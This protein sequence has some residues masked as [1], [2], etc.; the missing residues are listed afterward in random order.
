MRAVLVALLWMARASGL[1]SGPPI[2]WSIAGSDSGGG[3]GVEADLRTF[4]ALGVHGCAVVTSLTAQNSLGV[5]AALETPPSHVAATIAAL[6][7]DLAPACVKVGMLSGAGAAAREVAAFL[8]RNAACRLVLDPVLASS[9]GRP[10]LDAAGVAVLVGELLPRCAV[11]TPNARE[12]EALLGLEPGSVRTA[13]DV[14]AAAAAFLGR[15]GCGSVLLGGHADLGDAADFWTDGNRTAWLAG[16]RVAGLGA[17][18]A[19]GTGCVLVGARGAASA[20]N[21]L[22]AAVAAKAFCGAAIAL[23]RSGAGRRRRTRRRRGL[24]RAPRRTACRAGLGRRSRR[25]VPPV[26]ACGSGAALSAALR[27]AVG[28]GRRGS[29]AAGAPAA[30]WVN[31]DWRLAARFGAFGAHL[32][33]EDLAAL[34]DG[35]LA[36]LRDSGLRLGVSTHCLSE[37]AVAAA[38]AP[39]YV[40]LGPVFAT[41]SKHVPFSPRGLDLVSDWRALVPGDVPLVAI[42]GV[43]LD[44]AGGLGHGRGPRRVAV[45]GVRVVEAALGPEELVVPREA[46]DAA[47]GRRR[48]ALQVAEAVVGP[49]PVRAVADD[50]ARLH[51][52]GAAAAPLVAASLADE[53]RRAGASRSARPRRAD[54]ADDDDARALVG[55]D[56]RAGQVRPRAPSCG[57]CVRLGLACIDAPPSRRGRAV[58]LG[59]KTLALR[60]QPAGASIPSLGGAVD[61][62]KLIQEVATRGGAPALE[63]ARGSTTLFARA[64]LMAA[65]ARAPLAEVF[66]VEPTYAGEFAD[67]LPP[68]NLRRARRCPAAPL[69]AT[70]DGGRAALRCEGGAEIACDS[71]WAMSCYHGGRVTVIATLFREL[72]DG[73]PALAP[74]LGD[75]DVERELAA[76]LVDFI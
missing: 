41:T 69:H 52:H 11:A 12:A 73:A 66:A 47:A 60:Q 2:A 68:G 61:A 65:Q 14:E 63:H 49:R 44:A 31:D 75:A 8:E 50:V 53:P 58:T 64:A 23:R 34:G 70:A 27:G 54:V 43:T 57:R 19:H 33:Q 24:G 48:E 42:G 25:A 3:A 30:L 35:D 1:R 32:G 37:L 39:S 59:P 45:V 72:A 4:R 36:E 13:G 7:S 18:G 71:E 67:V 16:G 38:L 51:E 10:L 6:E 74:L 20:T 62:T 29:G 26:A 21:S 9:S 76:S 46:H 22:D 56:A 55:G 28:R 40:A 15:F 17:G 5:A